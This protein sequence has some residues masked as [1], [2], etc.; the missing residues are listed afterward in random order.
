LISAP[1]RDPDVALEIDR[2]VHR[3][4]ELSSTASTAAHGFDRRAVSA[5]FL[6]PH[7]IGVVTVACVGQPDIALAVDGQAARAHQMV[8][9][10]VDGHGLPQVA[11]AVIPLQRLIPRVRHPDIAV[12]GHG[13][14][15]RR[16]E[17]GVCVAGADG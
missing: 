15:F 4:D 10:R 14:A 7:G 16:V 8:A 6:Q 17:R 2:H 13:Q 5:V 11:G 9:V 12:H 3:I 1:V